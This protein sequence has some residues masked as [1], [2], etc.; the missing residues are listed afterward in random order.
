M[1]RVTFVVSLMVLA[2]VATLPVTGQKS[3][4]SGVWKIDKLKSV[5]PEYMP[6][7]SKISI[8]IEGDSL[9]TERVYDTGDGQEYPFNENITLDGK[10]YSM[11]IYDMPRK[12]KANWSEQDGSL[13]IE[14]TT[15]F[16]GQNGA[17]D[18]ISRETWRIDKANNTFT[19]NF[20]N[21]ITGGESEG[22]FFFNRA[23]QLK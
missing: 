21:T 20:K 17:E 2:T 23:D 4:Y 3:D 5:L 16:N 1:K 22:Y 15:T 6:T 9:F 13:I 12:L 18:F 14:S 7:L 11:T 8:K 19:I 10:E